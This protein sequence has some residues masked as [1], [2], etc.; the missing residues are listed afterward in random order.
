[1]ALSP[2]PSS[3]APVPAAQDPGPLDRAQRPIALAVAVLAVLTVGASTARALAPLVASRLGT[4]GIVADWSN[5]LAVAVMVLLF[6]AVVLLVQR[7]ARPDGTVGRG[8]LLALGLLTAALLLQGIVDALTH[9]MIRL[10]PLV[11][12]IS[13]SSRLLTY[14][15]LAL[16]ALLLLA[17]A[18]TSLLIAVRPARGTTAATIP[19]SPT[20]LAIGLGLTALLG[21]AVFP[22]SAL[23]NLPVLY[24][25]PS[26][27]LFSVL[28]LLLGSITRAVLLPVGAL[29]IARTAG[30]PR[31]L[32]WVALGVSWA[33][34]LASS[35]FIRLLILQLS[36]DGGA[37]AFG[38]W[39]GLSSAAQVLSLLSVLVLAVVV[40]VL[41][42][43]RGPAVPAAGTR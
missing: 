13:P 12:E 15:S 22:L 27:A 41:V 11:G 38:L 20:A 39:N 34:L 42:R 14:P 25:R 37:G 35:L 17:L 33:G 30:L 8:A 5:L 10:G 21:L 7:S 26:G 1:M 3:D 40:L 28:P 23:A 19:V 18:V 43:R 29:L 9:L 24:D 6:A 4:S 36:L 32:T 2:S 16:G 31:L